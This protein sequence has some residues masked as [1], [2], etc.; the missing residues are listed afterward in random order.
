MV[1]KAA[2]SMSGIDGVVCSAG[3]TLDKLSLRITDEDWD[4]VIA[5]NL[6][7]VFKINKSACRLMLKNK[8]GRIINISSVV[9][10]TGNIGQA[11]Y[12]AS[13]AGIIGM[14]KTM[15]LEFASRGITVNC[16]APGFIDTPMIETIPEKQREHILGSIPMG[17]MG[18]PEEI[19]SVALFLAS[20]ESRYITGQT[21][22]V[23]GGMIMC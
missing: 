9:G 20:D 18:S 7:S 8:S 5:V 22:H 1:D 15:A 16:V 6:T 14:S 2:E 21:I 17:R 3:I 4:K 13:K 19:A 10:I 11:N 12:A 23:N